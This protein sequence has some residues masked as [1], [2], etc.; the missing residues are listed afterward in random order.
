MVVK[1]TLRMSHDDIQFLGYP[2]DEVSRL[3][4]VRSRSEL[5]LWVQLPGTMSAT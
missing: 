3:S 4:S 1:I 2:G 5:K